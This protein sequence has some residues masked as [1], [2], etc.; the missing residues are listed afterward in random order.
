MTGKIEKPKGLYANC[1]ENTPDFVK[2]KV[3]CDR[4]LFM[5][6]LAEQTDPVC[7]FEVVESR[8]PDQYGNKVYLRIDQYATE[9]ARKDAAQGLSNAR[10]ALQPAQ[11][12]KDMVATAAP[13]QEGFPEDDIPF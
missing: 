10:Q 11:Q 9:K 3:K 13:T 6:W 2:T 4:N 8:E 12:V 1:Y 7:F 5:G